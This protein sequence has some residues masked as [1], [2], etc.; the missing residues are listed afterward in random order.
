MTFHSGRAPTDQGTRS[1]DELA[2]VYAEHSSAIL[3]LAALLVPDMDS[4]HEAMYEAFAA[5]YR[6]RRRL[7]RPD[8][9]LDFL[10]RAVVFR[11]RTKAPPRSPGKAVTTAAT[12]TTVTRSDAMVIDGLAA[13]PDSQ[14]EAIVLRYYGQ[15]SDAQAAAAMGVRPAA[16]RANIVHGMATLRAA[17]GPRTLVQ[18]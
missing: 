4:A 13:L 12:A 18:D 15:L 17:L 3:K 9:S 2:L 5:L 8:E 6:E 10:R 1:G 7:H 16:L 11:A 14:R